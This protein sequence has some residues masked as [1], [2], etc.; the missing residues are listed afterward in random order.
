MRKLWLSQNSFLDLSK[1]FLVKY[2]RQI[3]EDSENYLYNKNEVYLYKPVYRDTKTTL[4]DTLNR[5][6]ESSMLYQLVEDLN[7]EISEND[8]DQ[9]IILEK[10]FGRELSISSYLDDV[11]D[12]EVHFHISSIENDDE[13]FI[14]FLEDNPIEGLSIVEIPCDHKYVVLKVGRDVD[15]HL[16]IHGKDFNIK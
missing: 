12:Y 3:P 1:K 9:C 2:L 5:S 13:N 8:D 14:N 15:Y 7:E 6:E 4:M 10:Y 16:L 11:W